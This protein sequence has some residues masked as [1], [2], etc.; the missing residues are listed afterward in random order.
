MPSLC[1]YFQVHQPVRLRRYTFFDIGTSAGYA[2]DSMNWD[3]L[4][5]VAS[6]CYLPANKVMLD[7]I[8][9]FKGDFRIAYSIS[10]VALDQFQQFAPDVI[11]SFQRLADTGCVEFLNETYHHS[12]AFV[13]S[14]QEFAEQVELHQRRIT[15]LFGRPAVT[16]RNTELIYRDDLAREVERLGYRVILAEGADRILRRRSPNRIYQPAGCPN[17]RLLVK[18]YRLS[19]D[20]AFRFTQRDGKGRP[21]TA[22]TFARRLHALRRSAHTINLF[23]DYETFGEH[24][25]AGTGI[26]QFLREL[27]GAVLAHPEFRFRTP[28]EAA[29]DHAPA[30]SLPVPEFL[31]WADIERDL[32]A[33]L[34]NQMQRDAA[35]ALYALEPQVKA[36]RDPLVLATWRQLQTSDHFYYMC[37]KHSGDGDVHQYFTPYPSPYDAYIHFMN[38]LS[39]FRARLQAGT[40]GQP[41]PTENGV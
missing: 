16:F 27:P 21:L 37:T 25:W 19:D 11:S 23:M 26:F 8:R 22:A 34:G 18:N 2:D 24:H 20:I 32:S 38:V 15:G 3:V 28:A 14:R 4:A 10:G 9:A 35:E 13:F 29:G 12:L 30:G 5:K 40:P 7:L 6:K 41:P 36:L 39:D 33:W 1:F 31:S 17:L